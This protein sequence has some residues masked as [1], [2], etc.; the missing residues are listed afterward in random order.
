MASVS[1]E[2][3]DVLIS[4][5][6]LTTSELDNLNFGVIGFNANEIIT[7]YNAPEASWAGLDQ[8]SIIGSPIFTI[9]APCMNNYLIAERLRC[10]REEGSSLDFMLEYVLTLRM[11]PTP[12]TLRVLSS[13]ASAV[14]FIL[15]RRKG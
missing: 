15:V 11:R 9:V 13:R 5:N 4:L 10:S 6:S 14:Q 12:V 8:A 1:F 2:D 3:P 7:V